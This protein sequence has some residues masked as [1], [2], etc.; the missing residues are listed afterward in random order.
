MTRNADGQFAAPEW[1]VSVVTD[2]DE[3][4]GQ[5]RQTIGVKGAIIGEGG[6]HRGDHASQCVLHDLHATRTGKTYGAT[7][8]LFSK[9]ACVSGISSAQ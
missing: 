5:S 6:D 1:D 2:V 3:V 9:A 8:P 7:R 4:R